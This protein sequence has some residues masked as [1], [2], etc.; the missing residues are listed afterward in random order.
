MN[1][2]KSS[3]LDQASGMIGG[4]GPAGAA[5]PCRILVVMVSMGCGGYSRLNIWPDRQADSRPQ[6]RR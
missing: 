3:V 5:S 1:S 4:N 6:R 2:L